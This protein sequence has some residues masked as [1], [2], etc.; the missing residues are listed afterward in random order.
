MLKARKMLS[1]WE[2]PYIQALVKQIETQS[3]ATLLNWVLNYTNDFLLPLWEKYYPEDQRPKLALEAACSWTAG[4]IKLP[5]AKKLILQ[6][7]A[8]AREAELNPVAQASARAIGQA[9]STIHSARHCIG[10]PLYGALA[11]AYENLGVSAPWELVEQDA[12]KECKNM[13]KAL[14]VISVEDEKNLA[15][16]DWKC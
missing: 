1:D 13:L 7:H 5:Q 8:A 3:K 10:L 9:A 14:R 4:E 16:I 11:I 6:C 12:A 15:K 2:A